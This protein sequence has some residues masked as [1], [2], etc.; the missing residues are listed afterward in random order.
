VASL[1]E[2]SEE[3]WSDLRG[4]IKR[5]EDACRKAFAPNVFNWGCLMN[6]AFKE[7]TPTPHV[8][9]HVRPR[10]ARPPQVG[11]YRYSDPNFGQHYDS[12]A[13]RIVEDSMLEEIRGQ[14]FNAL[15]ETRG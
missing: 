4:V 14:I 1:S 3:Q 6:D 5:Y 15:A 10:Y 11:A 8:H 7:D 2:L 13:T 12:S 9:W